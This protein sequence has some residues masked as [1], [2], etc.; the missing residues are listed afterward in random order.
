MFIVEIFYSTRDVI[1]LKRDFRRESS[2]RESER[3]C[4]ETP[5]HSW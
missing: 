1:Q 2:Y 3:L 5:P 4:S